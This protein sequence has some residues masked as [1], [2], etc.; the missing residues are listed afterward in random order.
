[1]TDTT[2]TPV[3]DTRYM[4]RKF[5]FA[6]VAWVAGTTGWALGFALGMPIMTT[7]QWILFTQWIVGLYL[8]GNVG[9]TLVTGLSNVFVM[10]NSQ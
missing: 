5:I 9:D 2:L 1:M 3:D 7:E 8:A 10:R 6:A 4:S